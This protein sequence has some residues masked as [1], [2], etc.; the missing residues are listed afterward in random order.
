MKLTPEIATPLYAAI[1][2]DTGWYEETTWKFLEG[3]KLDGAV[4]E[5]SRGPEGQA[6]CISRCSGSRS[7]ARAADATASRSF[8]SINRVTS[9]SSSEIL[10]RS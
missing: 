10:I 7:R 3:V 5:V 8:S 6:G 2:T 1:A 9:A 4:I